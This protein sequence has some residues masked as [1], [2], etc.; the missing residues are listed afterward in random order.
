V[1]ETGSHTTAHTTIQSVQTR[2]LDF[3]TKQSRFCGDFHQRPSVRQLIGA[4]GASSSSCRNT[5]RTEPDRT[6]LRQPKHLLRKAAPRSAETICFTIGEI[7]RAFTPTEWVNYFRNS[8][9]AQS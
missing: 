8:G 5:R 9:Y 3:G 4:A 7:P 1:A 2:D 6:C